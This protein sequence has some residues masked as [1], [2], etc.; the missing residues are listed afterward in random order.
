M[1]ESEKTTHKYVG[2]GFVPGIPARDLTQDDL[3]LLD[4]A[5]TELLRQDGER[6]APAFKHHKNLGHSEFYK[7]A[8][9]REKADKAAAKK[10]G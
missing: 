7:E 3:D 10:E 1:S 8:Q 9:K 4:E 5:E 2:P 6:E